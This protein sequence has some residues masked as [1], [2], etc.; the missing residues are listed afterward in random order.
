MFYLFCIKRDVFTWGIGRELY[1]AP[2][3]WISSA[4][5]PLQKKGDKYFCSDKFSV[6]DISYNKNRE[7]T[8]LTIVNQHNEVMYSLT[9][10]NA[11]PS[12]EQEH[13]KAGN[14]KQGKAPDAGQLKKMEGE[15][16]RTG[17]D[18]ST[19]LER[20]HLQDISQ[21]TP[22]IYESAMRGLRKTKSKPA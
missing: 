1:T 7:I 15:L 10:K 19:V 20:Y 21:I 16:E 3:I 22:D 13:G 11:M 12:L 9:Q 6:K 18:L 4:K 14:T 5:T 17:V 8:E 2:F